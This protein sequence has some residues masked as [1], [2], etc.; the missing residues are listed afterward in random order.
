MSYI[1]T[2][3]GIR[4]NRRWFLVAGGAALAAPGIGGSVLAQATEAHRFAV[5]DMS[6]WWSAT[7][8]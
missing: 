2:P 7:A 3:A 6:G 8:T 5:G 4:L 1:V